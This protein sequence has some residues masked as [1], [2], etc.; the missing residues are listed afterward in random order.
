M[1]THRMAPRP[2]DG[3]AVDRGALCLCTV[4]PS[5]NTIFF[6]VKRKGRVKTPEYSEWLTKCHFELRRQGGWHVPG[7]VRVR[8]SYCRSQTK[9]DLDNLA[10]PVLDL[11]VQAGRIQDDR[12]VVEL[13]AAYGQTKGTVIEIWSA[14]HSI[15]AERLAP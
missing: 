11:L 4:P 2:L 9:A 10:K 1:T 14:S 8:L 13:H 6:N 7:H 15:T 5:L 12:N 3:E